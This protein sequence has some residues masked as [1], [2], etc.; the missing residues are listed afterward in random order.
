MADWLMGFLFGCLIG[1]IIFAIM[2]FLLNKPVGTLHIDTSDPE[3]DRYSFDM[4]CDLS[5]LPNHECVILR[6]HHTRKKSM[7]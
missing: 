6:V 2:F 5:G 1:A 3:T 7:L 4:E